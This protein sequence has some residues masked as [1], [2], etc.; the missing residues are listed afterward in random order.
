ME[1]E[2]EFEYIW[3]EQGKSTEK[4]EEVKLLILY[5]ILKLK[6]EFNLKLN[7]SRFMKEYSLTLYEFFSIVT[8]EWEWYWLSS[9]RYRAIFQSLAQILIKPFKT[10]VPQTYFIQN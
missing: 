5:E 4:L 3:T 1:K 7:V 2:Q 9:A 6:Y 10:L 8:Q